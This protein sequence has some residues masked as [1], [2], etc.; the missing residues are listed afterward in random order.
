MSPSKTRNTNS[1]RP[2][3]L[4]PRVDD[5]SGSQPEERRTKR[6]YVFSQAELQ[7]DVQRFVQR[8]TE[9]VVQAAERLVDA[10]NVLHTE[11]AVRRAVLCGGNALEIATGPMPELNLLDMLVFVSLLRGAFT[12]HWQPKVFQ[13]RGAPM[14]D[15]L[16]TMEAEA[17]ELSEKYLLPNQRERLRQE[18]QRWQAAHP[19]QYR[20]ESVRLADFAELAARA[21]RTQ[22]ER[23]L[24]EDMHSAAKIADQALLFG[25]RALFWAQH[26][27]SIIRL[28]VRLGAL[29][30]STDAL[31]QLEQ[32]RVLLERGG[33][34]LQQTQAL[35]PLLAQTTQ[36]TRE[37]AQVCAQ[38]Q[39]LVDSTQRLFAPLVAERAQAVGPPIT[40]LEAVAQSYAQ[41][42]ANIRAAVDRTVPE[43]GGVAALLE[44]SERMLR[45]VLGHALLV[46]GALLA[47]FWLGY[48]LAH[49]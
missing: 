21:D 24:L 47:L 42:G 37:L 14:L 5:G 30:V 41:L 7:H 10:T 19:G 23:S 17:W 32:S 40:A 1:W 44:R 35:A 46:G 28:Q 3:L 16:T 4:R 39:A 2:N 20:V 38:S 33:E 36:L 15:A 12:E 8:F 22:G 43:Q 27:P 11:A 29:E 45:R 48:Y 9:S 31:R 26:A 49:R 25:D 34:L 18:I 13:E 6:A